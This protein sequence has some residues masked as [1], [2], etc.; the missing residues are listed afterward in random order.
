MLTEVEIENCIVSV[1]TDI[2]QAV[3]VINSN[4]ARTAVVISADSKAIGTITV[5]DVWRHIVNDGSL[6]DSVTAIMNENFIYA[7][8]E[9][10][11]SQ[12]VLLMRENNIRQIPVLNKSRE[13]VK[14]YIKTDLFL[15]SKTLENTVV[16]MGGKGTRLRPET[17]SSP[18]PLIKIDNVPMIEIVINNVKNMGLINLLYQ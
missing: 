16:I 18:K 12:C 14:Q 4:Y 3:K 2:I 17:L 11:N 5:G 6:T 9:M 8:E 1:S 15:Y 7:D 10:S 13:L